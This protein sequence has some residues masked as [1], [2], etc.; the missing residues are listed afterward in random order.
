MGVQ[1]YIMYSYTF[2]D[3]IKQLIKFNSYCCLKFKRRY[4]NKANVEYPKAKNT[5]CNIIL[6]IFSPYISILNCIYENINFFY[7]NIIIINKI[8]FY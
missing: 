8:E 2:K 3:Q 4:S 6:V 5:Q 1:M 7:N